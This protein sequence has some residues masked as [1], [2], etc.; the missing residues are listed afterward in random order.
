MVQS[1]VW[2][3][4]ILVCVKQNTENLEQKED[5]QSKATNERAPGQT[6]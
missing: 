6:N 5:H 2:Q 1:I 4:G 3:L